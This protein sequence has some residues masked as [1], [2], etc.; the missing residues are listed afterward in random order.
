MVATQ[1]LWR[2]W[3]KTIINE[4]GLAPKRLQG[5]KNRQDRILHA[6]FNN[7][8]GRWGTSPRCHP[9]PHR[10]IPVMTFTFPLP[11][12]R[13]SRLTDSSRLT[14]IYAHQFLGG[15]PP[16]FC[17]QCEIYHDPTQSATPI[18][19]AP[20]ESHFNPCRFIGYLVVF[21][22]ARDVVYAARREFHSTVLPRMYV[23][24]ED[25][26]GSLLDNG[27]RQLR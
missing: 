23:T 19:N 3:T 7:Q 4:Q 9:L 5:N 18:L 6:I 11:I 16:N 20:L 14:I 15:Y 26:V 2:L 10:R 24:T 27:L 21:I 13:T 25:D 1:A 12:S 8:P 22:K 17:L